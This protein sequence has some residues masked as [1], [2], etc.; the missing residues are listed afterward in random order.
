MSRSS[1]GIVSGLFVLAVGV[2]AV[3]GL[4][5]S[6]E[7]GVEAAPV[8]APTPATTPTSDP[9]TTPGAP[10]LPGVSSRISRVLEWNGDAGFAGDAELV[11][12]PPTVADVLTHYGVPLRVPVTEETG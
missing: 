9:T 2:I 1:W 6:P 3:I 7:V 8:T 10:E 12:L 5:G 4:V 11:Q